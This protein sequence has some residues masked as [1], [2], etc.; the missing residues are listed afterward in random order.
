[1]QRGTTYEE[2][3]KKQSKACTDGGKKAIKIESFENDTEAQTRVK[4]GGSVA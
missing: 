4:S 3:L 1:M 2:A